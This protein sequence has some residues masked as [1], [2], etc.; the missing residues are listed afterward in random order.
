[1][2]SNNSIEVF[3]PTASAAAYLA[4][5]RMLVER[6]LAPGMA[7]SQLKL[8]RKLGC[9][10]QP[11]LEAMRRLES[12][13]L[14]VKQPRKMARVRELS[15]SELEG[16][17]LVRE[18]LEAVTA[19]LCAQK[20][21]DEQVRRLQELA[22][23]FETAWVKAEVRGL[24]QDDVAIHRHVAR[25]ADCP[26]LAEELDRLMLIE[27]T[28]G[29]VIAKPAADSHRALVLAIVDRDADSAEYLMKKHIQAG[30]RE[31]LQDLA[32]A[33]EN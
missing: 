18:G 19:R 28:A 27:R 32:K 15:A 17:F 7:V 10:P 14:I 2:P 25:C 16:L 23:A 3:K 4:I 24:D 33:G 11:V 8:S 21:T 30:Y 22:D 20:I 1:M 12:E 5:R 29:R 13:G 9:S 31:T 6:S 26:L